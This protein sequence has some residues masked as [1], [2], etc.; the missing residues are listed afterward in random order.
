MAKIKIN[1]NVLLVKSINKARNRDLIE[2]Q[3]QSGLRLSEIQEQ[4]ATSDVMATTI[5]SFLAQHNAGFK[6]RW[7]DLLD[8]DFE[9]IGEFI[10]EAGDDPDAKAEAEAEKNPTVPA[11]ETSAP[12][13]AESQ[14]QTAA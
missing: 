2:L 8:G 5:L 7:A 12:V 14:D 11:S 3:L 1:G 10:N 4:G 9:S 13:A 6:V